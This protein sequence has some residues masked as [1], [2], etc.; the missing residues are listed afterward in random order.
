M[1]NEIVATTS[2]GQ[3]SMTMPGLRHII[4]VV[5]NDH[6]KPWLYSRSIHLIS[7]YQPIYH[8][9]LAS[10]QLLQENASITKEA[11]VTLSRESLLNPKY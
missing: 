2:C 4:N 10:S 11:A 7:P 1:L 5:L 8:F 6:T 9:F 3:F